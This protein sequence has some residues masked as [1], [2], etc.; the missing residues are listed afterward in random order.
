MTINDL[1]RVYF[2]EAKPVIGDW[3]HIVNA[4]IH[5]TLRASCK[6]FQEAHW[7]F[8]VHLHRFTITYGPWYG[9]SN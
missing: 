7:N 5:G 4:T 1:Q 3:C 2:E 8:Y 6:D 9:L